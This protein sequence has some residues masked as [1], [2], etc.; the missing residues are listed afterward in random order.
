MKT[1]SYKSLQII[2]NSSIIGSQRET[3]IKVV[4]KNVSQGWRLIKIGSF[5]KI[6]QPLHNIKV[7]TWDFNIILNLMKNLS[8]VSTS[9]EQIGNCRPPPFLV[10]I[11]LRSTHTIWGKH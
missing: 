1:L 8:L 7:A 6:A 11:G 9:K 3:R 5:L 10:G 2:G 4:H